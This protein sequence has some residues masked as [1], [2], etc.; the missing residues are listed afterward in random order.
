MVRHLQKAALFGV[1]LAAIVCCAPAKS[2]AQQTQAKPGFVAGFITGSDQIASQT[3]D[4]KSLLLLIGTQ[5]TD[6]EMDCSHFVQYL[7]EQAGLYYGYTP[8]RVLYKGIKN[9]KR[10]ARPKSGDLIVWQGHVGIVVNPKETTF[11]SAL[12]SGVKTASY[13][14]DYWKKRG[15]PRFLRYTGQPQEA[16]ALSAHKFNPYVSAQTDGSE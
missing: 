5:I 1:C 13:Q 6:T 4:A 14:S 11:L 7:Y 15:R 16:P 9:F 10:V 3:L 12:N 2:A 8:S